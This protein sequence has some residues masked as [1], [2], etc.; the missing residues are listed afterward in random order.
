MPAR[1]RGLDLS[2]PDLT[3]EEEKRAFKA[4]YASVLGRS[5]DGLNFWLDHDP[6]VLKRYRRFAEAMVPNYEDEPYSVGVTAYLAVYALTGFADGVRYLVQ[7]NQNRG[8]S[9]AQN[10]EAIALAFLHIGPRGMETVAHALRDFEWIEEPETPA[11]FPPGW[12]ADP[13]AFASGLDF[14]KTELSQAEERSL[15][16][17]YERTLGEVPSYARLLLK[18]QP[19]L[20]KAYRDR[21]EN[22]LKTLPKQFMS[23]SLLC[24]NATRGNREGIRENLLLGRA[25][26][27][28]K[29]ALMKMIAYGTL[30]G[31][32]ESLSV[33]EATAGDL[34]DTWPDEA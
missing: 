9:K 18:H 6:S 29:S 17:W 2:N 25:L 28:S 12:K 7:V 23:T 13:D 14:T 16:S 5:H 22:T 32:I 34:L 15:V 26:G 3:T 19:A 30:Y 8:F 11:A 10:L 21:Y 31:G 20:L 33:V 24:L 27:V 4:A 1:Q